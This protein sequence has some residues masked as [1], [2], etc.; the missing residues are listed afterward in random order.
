MARPFLSA[1]FPVLSSA[2]CLLCAPVQVQQRMR[3]ALGYTFGEGTSE[4]AVVG[5][6]TGGL[7]RFHAACTGALQPAERQWHTEPTSL[8]WMMAWQ[9]R[10]KEHAQLQGCSTLT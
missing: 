8:L 9:A 1:L 2:N 7:L 4:A 3:S 5:A 6:F 10:G